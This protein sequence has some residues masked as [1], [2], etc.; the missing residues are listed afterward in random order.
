MTDRVRQALDATEKLKRIYKKRHSAPVKSSEQNL[1]KSA[2]APKDAEDEDGAVH[3]EESEELGDDDTKDMTPEQ[4]DLD[5]RF[6]IGY[7]NVTGKFRTWRTDFKCGSRVPA[8][9]DGNET[10]CD[11][12]SEM[13]CCSA[14][15]WCGKSKGHCRCAVC[16]DY[17]RRVKLGLRSVRQ[18]AQK[19]ECETIAENLGTSR[20]PE[21]CAKKAVKKD[22]CGKH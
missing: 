18:V 19:R 15:G 12:T 11:P 9:P 7:D 14:E 4:E 3:E 16:V 10:G 20:T 2:A 17:R 5:H 22:G 8:L 13:P 6:M 21:D 1:E